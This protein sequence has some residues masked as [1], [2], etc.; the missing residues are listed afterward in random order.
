MLQSLPS[1]NLSRQ[2][3]LKRLALDESML[4]MMPELLLQ[5]LA[6]SNVNTPVSLLERFGRIQRLTLSGEH[7]AISESIQSLPMSISDVIVEVTSFDSAHARL[8]RDST[9]ALGMV[10]LRVN[11]SWTVDAFTES[12]CAMVDESMTEVSLIVDS[13]ALTWFRFPSCI[14]NATNLSQLSCSFCQMPN[15]TD[16]AHL[17]LNS[18]SLT[19][20][21]GTWSQEDA[22]T[23]TGEFSSYFDWSWLPK[24]TELSALTMSYSI[25]NGTFPNDVS[26]PNLT[27]LY[28]GPSN[29]AGSI[30]PEWFTR[31]PNLAIFHIKSTELAGTFPNYG[32]EHLTIISASSNVFSHWPP[33]VTNSTPG[34]GA[35]I[36]LHSIDFGSNSLVRIPSASDFRSM[37]NLQALTL[38]DNPISGPL[39]DILDTTE[40]R[41]SLIGL[42]LDGCH[43]SG[44]LP[45]IPSRQ[46]ALFTQL[47]FSFVNNNLSGTIPLSWKNASFFSLNL[48]GNNGVNGTLSSRDGNTIAP[49]FIKDVYTLAMDSSALTGPMF[50]LSDLSHLFY[51]AM[52]TPNIDFCVDARMASSNATVLYPSPPSLQTC[53]L[54]NTNAYQCAW[55]YPSICTVDSTPPSNPFSASPITCALP[56]PGPLFTC[57]D[58]KWVSS[59]SVTTTTIAVPPATTVIVNGNLTTQSI[60]ITSTSS[61]INVT[62]CVMTPDG[63][64]PTITLVL[65]QSDLETIVK[66][67]GSLKSLLIQ[68]SPSCAPL[69]PSTL[70]IDASGV[71]SCKT[72]KTDKVE[73]NASTLS[74][75]FSVSSSKCNVWWIALIA[76]LCALLVIAVV[77][78]SVVHCVLKKKAIRKGHK[79]LKRSEAHT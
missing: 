13:M 53:D 69:D 21:R 37:T 55:A 11:D 78:I 15:F 59:G 75:T 74:V 48:L 68:Q 7:Y 14:S 66:N 31:F 18:L 30:A 12:F 4:D 79:A 6:V 63:S 3:S 32:L 39:P 23:N 77:V 16:L 64:H 49:S 26:H 5:E 10:V 71:Q 38:N 17:P 28:L 76:V 52:R 25:P 27:Q 42:S 1:L 65:T 22:G 19:S 56:S 72:I 61:T 24:L 67:G 43:F 46:T 70:Q 40:L 29:I 54:T 2:T 60:V 8:K 20:T 73:G 50:N 62:G 34:F 9:N 47:S 58:G 41:T 33:L 44:S 35:P 36:K 45:E 57:I 51:L